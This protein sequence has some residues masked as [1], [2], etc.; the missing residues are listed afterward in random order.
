MTKSLPK[1]KYCKKNRF[2]LIKLTVYMR[3]LYICISCPSWLIHKKMPVNTVDFL[4]IYCI[5]ICIPERIIDNNNKLGAW[6]KLYYG[7][8]P[9]VKVYRSLQRNCISQKNVSECSF[10]ANKYW[11]I[12]PIQKKKKCP[13]NQILRIPLTASLSHC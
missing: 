11:E 2:N 12:L 8:V 6:A 13:K 1:A 10:F 4:N 7:T 9:H 5:L 3:M